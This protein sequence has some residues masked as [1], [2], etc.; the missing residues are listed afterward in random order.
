M[1]HRCSSTNGSYHT[2]FSP[3]F[4]QTMVRSFWAKF[5]R[6]YVCSFGGNPSPRHTTCKTQIRLSTVTK[7]SSLVCVIMCSKTNAVGTYLYSRNIYLQFLSARTTWT[8]PFSVVVLRQPPGTTIFVTKTT[9]P[10]DASAETPPKAFLLWLLSKRI[11]SMRC[12]CSIVT[13]WEWQWGNPQS[14]IQ[15]PVWVVC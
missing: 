1:L 4:S 11:W 9:L 15:W 14:R 10:V 13:Q 8:T 7:P 2:G 3:F 6:R 5:S 12:L